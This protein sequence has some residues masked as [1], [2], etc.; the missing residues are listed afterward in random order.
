MRRVG[1]GVYTFSSKTDP[2]Y[3]GF[4]CPVP[5]W[6]RG[7]LLRFFLHPVEPEIRISS[8]LATRRICGRTHRGAAFALEVVSLPRC[9]FLFFQ[10][11][12][13]IDAPLCDAQPPGQLLRAFS[14]PLTVDNARCYDN[15]DQRC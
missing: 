3:I 4:S 2:R 6:E 9:Q 8:T 7:F 5:D 12:D 10:R 15:S 1:R 11:A 13:G 14:L